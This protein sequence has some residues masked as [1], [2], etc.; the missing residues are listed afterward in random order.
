MNFMS[1]LNIYS[2][3]NHSHCRKAQYSMNLFK[4]NVYSGDEQQGVGGMFLK[5]AQK[6]I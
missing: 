3:K 4:K 2:N 6:E 1:F 5:L